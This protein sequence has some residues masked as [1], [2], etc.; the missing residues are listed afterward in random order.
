MVYR[1]PHWYNNY[2]RA[3][4]AIYVPQFCH[5]HNMDTM[6]RVYG[7][8]D[9]GGGPTRRDLEL[10]ID[11]NTWPVFPNFRFGTYQ[12]F[13]QLVE[14]QADQLPVVQNELNFVFTGC[15]TSQAR[16]KMANRIGEA[17]LKETE[18]FSAIAA[19]TVNMDYPH[20]GFAE[21]WRKILF[22]QFHDIIPGSG[23]IDTRE[24]AMGLF[25]SSMAFAGSKKAEALRLI[26]DSIDTS[27]LVSDEPIADTIAEG[28][29]V[30]FGVS[31]FAISQTSRG[32]GKSR[33]F[34]IFNSVTQPH[35]GLAE[36]VVWDWNGDLSHLVV[37][38]SQGNPVVH[39]LLDHGF[40][41]YWSHSYVRILVEVT[42]PAL[43]Y[44]TY[45]L[46]EGSL[47]EWPKPLPRDPRLEPTYEFVL[48]NDYIKAELNKQTGALSSLIDKESGL[49]LIDQASEGGLFRFIMED[50]SKGMTSWTLGRYMTIQNLTDNV[51]IK[52]VID[53]TGELRQA[54]V[55]DL[56]FA[57]SSSLKVTVS[58]ERGDRQ[59]RYDV[60]CEW[61]EV[62]RSGQGIPQLNFFLPLNY[63]CKK[64]KYDVPFG[65]IERVEHDMDVPANS[66]AFAMNNVSS[67][68][69]QLITKDKYGFRGYQNSLGLSLIRGSFDPD[70]H[71]ELGIHRFSFAVRVADSDSRNADLITQAEV[72]NHP[73]TAL[74]VK[75]AGGSLPMAHSFVYLLSGTAV[76]SAIK[77]PEDKRN[78]TLIV[79]LYETDGED[80]NVRLRFAQEVHGLKAVDIHEQV[81]AD[82]KNM[83]IEGN[84]VVVGL[85][86]NSVLTVRVDFKER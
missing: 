52:R 6:L 9:H 12:E 15:Y 41:R 71:P 68:A 82:A 29:G 69:V 20:D 17:A 2:I 7:V 66:W 48:E 11:M 44:S 25:Q 14:Q 85:S 73:L 81:I 76:I 34:H 4:A 16:I 21:A 8:G 57:S 3:D 64:Y 86:A 60:E 38:D 53:R 32:A 70:P 37:K 1:E 40:N 59:L 46:T 83:R 62:G 77:A 10:I 74:S 80:T 67:K 24:H 27:C 19:H 58:L 35:T 30:G 51:R 61:L 47:N 22:N 18:A 78:N 45:S 63:E 43:G 26:A 39:Q 65:A 75:P 36:I 13:Y 55:Y 72:F 28:A 84:D 79:R 50:E 49:E 31:D 56:K 42:V 33:V 23:T 54:V 5:K